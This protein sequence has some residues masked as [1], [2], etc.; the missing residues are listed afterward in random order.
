MIKRMIQILSVLMVTIMISCEDKNGEPQIIFEN[1]I[2]NVTGIL[3]GDLFL[4]KGR[5]ASN[6]GIAQAF[7]FHQKKMNNG[8]IDEEGDRL[9]LEEDGSFSLGFNADP[10]SIGVKIIAE[11]P[12]GNRVV[13]IFK[14]ILGTDDL[15]ITF[16]DPQFIESI[17]AGEEFHVK[18]TA[19]SKTKMT[20]L[21]YA[22]MR[23][24]IKETPVDLEIAS[25]NSSPF[26][27]KLEAKNGMTGILLESQNKGGL[28]T[29]KLFE[30]KKVV[31]QGPVILFDT[32]K[33]EVK[34]NKDFT[35]SGTITAESALTATSYIVV[36]GT[37]YDAEKPLTVTDGKFSIDI[38]AGK[39]VTGFIVKA[40]DADG[41][42]SQE[43]ITVNILFPTAIT[44]NAMIHYKYLVLTAE[45]YPQSYLSFTKEP[46]VL[47]KEQ[48]TANQADIHLIYLNCY[49]SATSA[50]NG[51]ALIGPNGNTAGTIKAQDYV[52]GWSTVNLSRLVAT[53][54]ITNGTLKTFDEIE[55]TAAEWVTMNAYLSGK[56][57]NSS[58]IRLK[59]VSVGYTFAVGYGGTAVGDINKYAICIVRGIGGR[60]ATSE[61][62]TGDAWIELEI[63]RSK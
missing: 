61:G 26:D 19:T 30:I 29:E 56:I 22:V 48:A 53:P 1:D 31:A 11:D 20:K 9:I 15:V 18:G 49:I 58:V 2:D 51:P 23:G 44:G 12:D 42:E 14:V 57:G 39:D 59:D 43:L 27:I 54:E 32:E 52:Q 17:E 47:N 38:N 46:Y 24:E 25:D 4:V 5:I 63:K 36:R 21:T 60:V 45:R 40:T 6:T 35:V 55:D 33:I 62:D 8:Q 3:P 37:A 34:P 41:G 28:K 10:A 7:Y 13:K 16:D 50:S